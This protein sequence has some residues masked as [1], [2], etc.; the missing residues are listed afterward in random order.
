MK[1]SGLSRPPEELKDL[2]LRTRAGSD[3]QPR[4]LLGPEA[5]LSAQAPLR[6]QP[7]GLQRCQLHPSIHTELAA[8]PVGGYSLR[9]H[10]SSGINLFLM[11]SWK[12]SL[13]LLQHTRALALCVYVYIPVCVC[14]LVCT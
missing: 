6:V 5:A 2:P 4:A 10:S 11:P 7:S 9:H 13:P 3:C 12:K 8:H 14:V 1:H